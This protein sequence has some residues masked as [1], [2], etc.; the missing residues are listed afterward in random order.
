VFRSYKIAVILPAHDEA[1]FIARTL[2]AVPAYVDRICAVDDASN[3]GTAEAMTA[4]SFE[5]KRITVLR[6][7]AN[8]GVG[9]AIITGY[10]AALAGG[11]D[12]VVVMDGDGQMH[13]DDLP[14]L[15]EPLTERRAELVKGNRFDGL[16][17][18]GRMPVP[19]HLG[20]LALSAAT[21]LVTG[22]SGPLDAQCGYTAALACSL[23]RLPFDDLYPRYGFPNDLFIRSL[24]AGL[25]VVSVPVRAVYGEE[26]SGIKPH[27]AIPRIL[28]LL[29]RAGHR[30][31]L[32]RRR[33]TSRTIEARVT[34]RP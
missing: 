6:H 3:D 15:L 27:V 18:R 13:P 22:F 25:R 8:A 19:R 33:V 30:R 2:R 14:T 9:A 20:N 32:A 7:H 26:V 11:A 10:R 31:L 21:R 28:G 34:S 29:V 4:A 5:D 16:R 24:E 17:S 12:I 23:E 1:R